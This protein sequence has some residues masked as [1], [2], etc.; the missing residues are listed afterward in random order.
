MVR[1]KVK[2]IALVTCS[3]NFERQ[4]RVVHEVHE[5]LQEMGDYALY[6]F[7]NYGVFTEDT[8]YNRGA[9][10]IYKL[11]TQH[12]FDGCIVESNIGN[13]DTADEIE[14][15]FHKCG[16]PSVALNMITDDV[17]FA[18]LDV[19]AAQ[20]QIMEHLICEHDCRKINF[21]GFQGP[22]T[23]TDQAMQA[24]KDVLE[25]YHIAYD[26]RRVVQMVVSLENGRAL[27]E[28]FQ[29]RGIDDAQATICIHD[30]TAI[31]YIL[32]LEKSGFEVPKDMK[33]CSLNCSSNSVGF[34]PM[35]TG[36]SR[37]EES[38]SR[39]ACK[40]II[41][42]MEGHA[43]ARENY[44]PGRIC[45]G[46]S[47]GC[48]P[49]DH[50][51]QKEQYQELILNKV[52]SGSQ[53]S[54]MMRYN[55]A[56]EKASS[57]QELGNSVFDM[58]YGC[59]NHEFL[60]CLN[61]RDI[62]YILNKAEDFGVDMEKPFDSTMVAVTGNFKD[63]G[64]VTDREF[65]IT[66]LLPRKPKAGDIYVFMPIHRNDR[67][68]G[69]LTYVNNFSAIDIYN[70]RILHE[71]VGS[72]LESL[73]RQMIL[74]NSIKEL[75]ELHMRD[76]LT[77][78]YNRYAQERYVHDYMRSG[79]YCI[80]MLDMD[81]MKKINDKYGHLAGNNALNIMAD[82]MR[83]CANAT[84][85]LVRY[86]GDEFLILSFETDTQYWDQFGERLNQTIANHAKKQKLPYSFGAS[87]G[88]Q[89]CH[90]TSYEDFVACY[91]AADEI[92]YQNKQERKSKNQ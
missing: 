46:Q 54:R 12:D 26:E 58:L 71:S 86:A 29:E 39:K 53:I 61:K 52:E 38:I 67:V 49:N 89:I 79:A 30:V 82:A 42:M 63:S 68:Y 74:R 85:L 41:D 18:V 2:K 37:Q 77:G 34:R 8:P 43:V 50:S 56:L 25:K 64:R 10:S 21:V 62:G 27:F 91:K 24:Y 76:A 48:T 23:F 80:V 40:I 66:E 90:Q 47:C 4:K 36:I 65:K 75:D 28:L 70:H 57:L 73:R 45:Y 22:D 59:R 35:I 15:E 14:I 19:Y 7:T 1:D 87:V 84:D 69:Y 3:S 83:D 60:L 51:E 92:M 44:F 11:I 33:V 17:P 72:S 6:V 55:D 32:E 78:L 13:P 9:K 31:G 88:Y 20:M 16:I 81:G 5:T